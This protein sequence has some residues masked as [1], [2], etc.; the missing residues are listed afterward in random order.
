[1]RYD[2]ASATRMLEDDM[3]KQTYRVI[4]KV[5]E[6]HEVRAN[7]P[8]EALEVALGSNGPDEECVEARWVEDSSGARVYD[9][10]S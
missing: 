8:E 10:S 1:M 3:S 9:D 2:A 6:I 7:S 4:T 5:T